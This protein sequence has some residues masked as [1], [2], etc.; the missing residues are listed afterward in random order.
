MSPT[1]QSLLDYATDITESG[2]DALLTVGS[3]RFAVKRIER[4]EPMYAGIII[5]ILSTGVEIA[6]DVDAI[7]AVSGGDALAPLAD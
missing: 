7:D 6:I 3:H 1:K 5:C 2:K 4:G